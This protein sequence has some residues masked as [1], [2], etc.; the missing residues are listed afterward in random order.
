MTFRFWMTVDFKFND[1]PIL[2]DW[3]RETTDIPRRASY[4]SVIKP[5]APSQPYYCYTRALRCSQIMRHCVTHM[6][7]YGIYANAARNAGLPTCRTQ[8]RRTCNQHVHAGCNKCK[9]KLRHAPTPIWKQFTLVNRC[10]KGLLI[11]TLHASLC[12]K[13]YVL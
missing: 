13:S 2:N 5:Y 4:T 6:K 10:F 1:I 12:I 9:Q 8:Q 7:L 11:A 3:G